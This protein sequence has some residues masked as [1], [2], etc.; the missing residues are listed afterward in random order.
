MSSPPA[1]SITS[2][3]DPPSS[4]FVRAAAGQVIVLVRSRS[5]FSARCHRRCRPRTT[6]GQS[7]PSFAA[8]S[9]ES[10]RHLVVVLG[11][12]DQ[13]DAGA[14]PIDVRLVVARC[15]KHRV[16]AVAPRRRRRRRGLPDS[17]CRRPRRRRP[18]RAVA[19]VAAAERRRLRRSSRSDSH[20][21]RSRSSSL[22]AWST[23][24]AVIA[25]SSRPRSPEPVVALLAVERISPGCR[26]GILSLPQPAAD[27]VEP[28][29]SLDTIPARAA[30]DQIR[31]SLALESSSLPRPV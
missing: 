19:T 28:D 13:V 1:P 17:C 21:P 9:S 24:V 16:L 11:V 15:R 20:R 12:G 29:G 27:R 2:S 22:S 8:W 25:S 31:A 26:P 18:D 3:P 4:R 6:C 23:V 5:R 14:A 10:H 7:W 30:A